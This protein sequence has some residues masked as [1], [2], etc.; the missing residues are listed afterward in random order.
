MVSIYGEGTEPHPRMP[1]KSFW[2]SSI[3]PQPHQ[4]GAAEYCWKRV[5]PKPHPCF[6]SSGVTRRIASYLQGKAVVHFALSTL[7]IQSNGGSCVERLEGK[8]V[9][10]PGFVSERLYQELRDLGYV[11]PMPASFHLLGSGACEE[12]ITLIRRVC[13]RIILR[14]RPVRGMNKQRDF[15]WFG[16]FL[17]A[18][19]GS[20]KV[21]KNFLDICA[22][23]DAQKREGALYRLVWEK[24]IPF[25]LALVI[26]QGLTSDRFKSYALAEIAEHLKGVIDG[27]R[28]DQLLVMVNGLTSDWSKSYVLAAIA[29]HLKGVIKEEKK[30][31][32]LLEMVKGM[33]DDQYKSSA[34]AAIAEP[35][36]GVIK[37]EKKLD[38][39]LVMV[40][41][42]T[43]DGYKSYVLAA[44][45]EHL[46]GVIKEE[47]KLDQLLEMVKGM[48][49]DKHKSYALNAIAE[50]L[51]GVIDGKRL[52]R[53]LVM[54][55][56]MTD[57]W[58]KSS[59]LNAI[60]EHLKG[61][62]DGK[63]LDRMLVMVNGMTDDWFKS[64]A[65]AAIA[66]PLKG[67][68]DGERFDQLLVMVNGITND[69]YKRYALDAIAKA[70]Q[71]IVRERIIDQMIEIEKPWLV[72]PNKVGAF[73]TIAWYLPLLR[74]MS[75][76]SQ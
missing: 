31:D 28:L 24:D 66:E 5:I 11:G 35:L 27:E 46:K 30:L 60:A 38:Q 73:M 71:G 76:N 49:D 33:T 19:S 10:W 34:L 50:H 48:T 41:G 57:D 1:A 63:R 69:R 52:D 44:I 53:M 29:E 37:E 3:L 12:E 64:S 65:L 68:I 8:R 39:L 47:K 74:I 14:I 55:N 21:V 40:N 61:V 67:V 25:D 56:G 7:S 2:D 58:F 70:C 54:V 4:H 36:K 32:Q 51:K 17:N 16:D 43:W 13:F 62:I 72:S 42:M 26:V 45:A 9:I 59:A 75:Y 20:Y 23:P 22:N 15:R 18:D 6:S